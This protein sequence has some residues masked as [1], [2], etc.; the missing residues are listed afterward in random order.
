MGASRA[1]R[2]AQSAPRASG[3]PLR[4]TGESARPESKL[5]SRWE[6]AIKCFSEGKSYNYVDF[7]GALL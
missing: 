6:W 1:L 4:W 5:N 3:F 7:R 2:C